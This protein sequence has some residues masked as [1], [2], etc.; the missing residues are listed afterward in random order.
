MTLRSSHG[1]TDMKAD[2][3][4]VPV[5]ILLIPCLIFIG[6]VIYLEATY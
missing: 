3:W 6:V 4:W 1:R 5:A 2:P